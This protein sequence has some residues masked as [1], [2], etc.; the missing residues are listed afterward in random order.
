MDALYL[1]QLPNSEYVGLVED[2]LRM[3]VIQTTIQF[4]YFINSNGGI[5]FFSADFF[6]LITYVVLGV[7]VY[8]LVFKKLI[9]FK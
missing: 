4:L 5:P 2:I 9:V 1:I 6:L 7:C 3:V 8:W